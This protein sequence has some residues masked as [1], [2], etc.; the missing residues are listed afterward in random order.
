MK[1]I[2]A[3][4][5]HFENIVGNIET[6]FWK[7]PVTSTLVVLAIVGIVAALL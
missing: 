2:E 5:Q 4:L 6:E 7:R 3:L 1:L